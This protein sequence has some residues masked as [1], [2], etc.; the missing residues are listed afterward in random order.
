M[1]KTHNE[2][3]DHRFRIAHRLSA[4][5][6]YMPALSI[7]QEILSA[8]SHEPSDS[9][10]NLAARVHIVDALYQLGMAEE[11]ASRIPQLIVDLE[12]NPVRNSG[13]LIRTMQ[14]RARCLYALK[15]FGEARNACE[16]YIKFAGEKLGP[17]DKAVLFVKS[18][19]V[20]VLYHGGYL[21]EAKNKGK[22]S[23]KLLRS[24]FG[25]DRRTLKVEELLASIYS[26][27]GDQAK[28]LRYWNRCIELVGALNWLNPE[29]K[30]EALRRF[31]TNANACAAL[32]QAGIEQR[33]ASA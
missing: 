18:L 1:A 28:A 33:L 7:W 27:L 24:V 3:G 31:E 12:K 26:R 16:Q 14:T 13:W 11:A 25:T 29:H 30:E 2:E 20:E 32:I 9:S 6:Q 21:L 23:V 5:K 10:A 15:H 22:V 19:Q 17:K 8:Y 4:L